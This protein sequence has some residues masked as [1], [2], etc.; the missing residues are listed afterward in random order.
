MNKFK[1]KFLRVLL[2]FSLLTTL[3]LATRAITKDDK[4]LYSIEFNYK[5]KDLEKDRNIGCKIF[6][7]Y[8]KELKN[9]TSA[10]EYVHFYAVMQKSSR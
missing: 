2:S 1:S 5:G 6:N 8:S 10:K 7:D 3:S 4:L 9:K